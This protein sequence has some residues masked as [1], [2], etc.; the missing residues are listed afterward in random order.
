VCRGRRSNPW[1]LV[2][3]PNVLTSQLILE[4][5]TSCY[6]WRQQTLRHLHTYIFSSLNNYTICN[7]FFIITFT[8]LFFKINLS[9]IHSFFQHR[10][11]SLKFKEIEDWRRHRR[12]S[13]FVI[14]KLNRKKFSNEP[15][16]WSEMFSRNNTVGKRKHEQFLK[17]TFFVLSWEKRKIRAQ[18]TGVQNVLLFF[19]DGLLTGQNPR[20]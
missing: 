7:N 6:I 18:E 5:V 17:I 15:D 10:L 11:D 1:L 12:S 14:K 4:P 8:V 2:Q 19:L 20:F 3:E 16:L 9:E 13:F